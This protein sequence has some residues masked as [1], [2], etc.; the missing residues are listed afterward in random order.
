MALRTQTDSGVTVLLVLLQRRRHQMSNDLTKR[1][2]QTTP[3]RQPKDAASRLKSELMAEALDVMFG[4]DKP[5][6]PNKNQTPRVILA[7]AN[8]GSSPGWDYAKVLQRE[9]FKAAGGNLEMKFA[10]YGPDDKQGVRRARIT[11]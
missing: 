6:V 10:C 11:T 8:H 5:V 9:M 3:E 7:L 4:D 2:G 1:T